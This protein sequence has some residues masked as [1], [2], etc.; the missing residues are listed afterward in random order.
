MFCDTRHAWISENLAESNTWTHT[1]LQ[2]GRRLKELGGVGLQG[3]NLS[4]N[5]CLDSVNVR[6]VLLQA[7]QPLLIIFC[8]HYL[9]P[10]LLP[11]DK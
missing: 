11:V 4:W 7:S 9:L 10:S 5:L 2:K 6:T 8:G 3:S 1:Y